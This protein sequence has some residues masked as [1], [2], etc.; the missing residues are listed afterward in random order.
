MLGTDLSAEFIS[1]VQFAF[2]ISFHI[3]FPAFSI[4]LATFLFIMEGAWLKT[5]NIAYYRI[6]RFWTKF[7][8]LLL[9]W[10]W[11]QV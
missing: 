5:K 11:F 2:T 7:L 9:V 10:V 1:R 4:G 3:L 8:L 6:C